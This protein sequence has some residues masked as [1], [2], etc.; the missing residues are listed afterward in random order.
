MLVEI[1]IG[2]AYGAGFEFAPEEKIN[3]FNDLQ[4]YQKHEKDSIEAGSY[5]D[6]TQMSLALAE[7]I[8]SGAELTRESIA[9]AFVMTFW[10]DPRLGYAKGFQGLLESCN[11]GSEL[12]AKITPTSTR[13]GA[14]MRSVPLCLIEKPSEILRIAEIQAKI[15][16]DTEWG[17]LSSKVIGIAAATLLRGYTIGDMIETVEWYLGFTPNLAWNARVKC[18]AEDTLH[19]VFASLIGTGSYSNLLKKAIS[20]GGDTDSVASV[21]MG[22]ASLSKEF[23]KTIPMNLFYGLEDG[24]FGHTHLNNVDIQIKSHLAKMLN[25]VP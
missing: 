10:K 17:I 9:D 22:L 14:M 5:T 3:N 8:L 19:A 23:N 13:N 7:L 20:F 12:L 4:S 6:D 16:H 1:A 2:D 18:D 15:T 11:D 21:A 25:K 24:K